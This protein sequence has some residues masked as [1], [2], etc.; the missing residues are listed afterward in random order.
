[1]AENKTFASKDMVGT[2][3]GYVKKK[4]IERVDRE[5]EPILEGTTGALLMISPFGRAAGRGMA[6]YRGY[7]AGKAVQKAVGA[8]KAGKRF[9]VEGAKTFTKAK[10]QVATPKN[11]AKVGGATGAAVGGYYATKELAKMRDAKGD[12]AKDRPSYQE[13]YE[14]VNRKH[15]T[16][17]PVAQVRRAIPIPKPKPERASSKPPIPKPKP[18]GLIPAKPAKPVRKAEKRAEKKPSFKANWMGAA[19]TA[20]QKRAGKRGSMR[21]GRER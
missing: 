1:M 6:A 4:D 3:R 7:K 9:S 11:V 17:V 5:M 21:Q 13:A 10:P 8:A 19:P 18:K 15:G 12:V 2:P 16:D 20:M 14:N